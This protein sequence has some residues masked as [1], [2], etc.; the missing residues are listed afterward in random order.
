MRETWFDT[1]ECS[2]DYE[3]HHKH[4]SMLNFYGT[5]RRRHPGWSMSQFPL[6][7]RC[8][9]AVFDHPKQGIVETLTSRIEVGCA[10]QALIVMDIM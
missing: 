6:R 5:E 9:L 4:Q 2:S 7:E 8:K 10:L 1:A 3:L